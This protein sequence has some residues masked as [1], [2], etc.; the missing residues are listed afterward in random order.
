MGSQVTGGLDIHIQNPL[1]SRVPRDSWGGQVTIIPKPEFKGIWGGLPCFSPSFKVTSAEVATF[2]SEF[3][4]PFSGEPYM[5]DYSRVKNMLFLL[6]C[7]RGMNFQEK[8]RL[9]FHFPWEM[10]H[11]VTTTKERHHPWNSLCHEKKVTKKKDHHIT[12][13]YVQ[14]IKA[15]Y[16]FCTPEIHKRVPVQK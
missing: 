5:I 12:S 16:I 11:E 14:Y 15:F 13:T 4:V 2:C 1:F 7:Y 8:Q 3:R 10:K 9:F 6:S